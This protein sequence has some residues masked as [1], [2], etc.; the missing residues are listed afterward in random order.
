MSYETGAQWSDVCA[1]TLLVVAPL[2]TAF[3]FFSK[4][5]TE[6]MMH[7]GIK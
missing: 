4:Q 1:A 5:F 3:L 6:G 2:L 7:T